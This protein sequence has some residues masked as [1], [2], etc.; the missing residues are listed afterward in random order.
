M[1]KHGMITHPVDRCECSVRYLGEFT[2]D[3]CVHGPDQV[4]ISPRLHCNLHTV[5]PLHHYH[6]PQLPTIPR[7]MLLPPLPPP[8]SLEAREWSVMCEWL[9][10]HVRLCCT[11]LWGCLFLIFLLTCRHFLLLRRSTNLL[12]LLNQ[13]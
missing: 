9:F 7:S 3:V 12:N 2:C 13:Y 11:N 5:M 1:Y 6:P 4:R 8:H 10:V